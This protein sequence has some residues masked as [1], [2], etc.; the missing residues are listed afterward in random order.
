MN[1]LGWG[2]HFAIL[3]ALLINLWFGGDLI[4]ERLGHAVRSGLELVLIGT[5]L[6][7]VV[8]VRPPWPFRWP[9]RRR[10]VDDGDDGDDGDDQ[11]R[12]RPGP[13]GS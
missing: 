9:R 12:E 5:W 1:G 11:Q 4:E 2:A 13:T 6:I 8:G 10:A 3:M 7:L